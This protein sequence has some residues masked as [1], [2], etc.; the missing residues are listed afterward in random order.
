M[1]HRVEDAEGSGP[2]RLDPCE[3]MVYAHNTDER[4]GRED[5]PLKM[6]D[7]R[8]NFYGCA[9]AYLLETWFSGW[10]DLLRYGEYR[11]QTYHVSVEDVVVGFSGKQ[12]VFLRD[13]SYADETLEIWW[14]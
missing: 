11:V 9:S 4:P 1:I 5:F 7:P 8:G 2:Y 14:D 12:L 10:G 6:P 13:K 3:E